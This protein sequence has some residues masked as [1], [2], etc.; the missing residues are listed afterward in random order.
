MKIL[1]IGAT[2]HI[3]SAVARALRQ[4]HEII[5]ASRAGEHRV[6]ITDAASIERLFAEV[7]PVDAVICSVGSV[8][9]APATALDADDYRAGFRGKTLAQLDVVR[10]ALDHLADDGSITL[11][12]GITARRAVPGGAV[13]SMANGALESFVIGAAPELPR[14]IRL[15]AVSPTVLAEATE[16]H[17]TF[18]A[19]PPVPA[20]VVA[21]AYVELVE[22]DRTGAVVAI[23]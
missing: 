20:A 3:G 12:T 22:G 7:G 4:G 10:I 11:T 5:E 9:W 23:D 1:I 14:G 18:A 16:Y 8:P 19:F 2:G 13:A 21:A 6:D 15:N 17:E